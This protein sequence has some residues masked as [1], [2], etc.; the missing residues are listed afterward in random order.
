[1][2]FEW[3]AADVGKILT[4]LLVPAA[5]TTI[6]R[7]PL[8]NYSSSSYDKILLNGKVVGLSMFGGYSYN[9]RTALSLGIVDPVV[10]TGD[11]LTLVWGEEN[12]GTSKPPVERHKQLDVQVKVS[13][14]PYA[15]RRTRGLPRGL[16]NASGVNCG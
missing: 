12:G 14:V 2:T 5:N 4:S 13:A 1:V 9:E 10:S 7:F 11:V 8:A 15:T 3:N 16:A 6:L